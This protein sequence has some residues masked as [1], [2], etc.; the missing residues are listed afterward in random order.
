MNKHHFIHN[1]YFYLSL[2]LLLKEVEKKCIFTQK[3]LT[4][5]YL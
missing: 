1:L 2:L 5:Y 4:T 3:C